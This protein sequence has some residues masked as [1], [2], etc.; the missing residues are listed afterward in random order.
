MGDS[1]SALAEAMRAIDSADRAQVE[2]ANQT[3]REQQERIG[4]E[5]AAAN[6]QRL[7]SAQQLLEQRAAG[8]V[9]FEGLL[10]HQWDGMR[11]GYS[12]RRWLLADGM[13]LGKTRTMIGWLDLQA[14]RRTVIVC[15]AEIA[16][17]FG[18]EILDVAPHRRTTILTK[19]SPVRRERLLRVAL[20]HDGIIV[21]NFEL[22]RGRNG[23]MSRLLSDLILWQA[24]TV[25]VDEAHNMKT[26]KS[27]NYQLVEQL[28]MADN[29]CVKCGSAML[30]VRNEKKQPIPCGFCGWKI[31]DTPTPLLPIDRLMETKSVK[32]LGLTTGTP[33]LNS[34]EDLYP[35]LHLIDPI[36]FP[37]KKAFTEAFCRIDYSIGG[38]LV[39]LASGLTQLR[40]MI[41]GNFLART[42]AD[43][44]IV[45]PPQ[46]VHVVTV[47]IDPTTHPDQARV[48]RQIAEFAKIT[49]QNGNEHTIMHAM[50][51]LTRKRQS[52]VW[53]AGIEIRDTDSNSPTHG[54]VIFRVGDEV[55]E[56]AK[57]DAL[58]ANIATQHARGARQ[59]VFSQFKTALV[60]VEKRLLDAGYH[61]ARFDGD[62]PAAQREI[63]KGDFYTT[64]TDYKYDI[65][66]VHYRSGGTGLNLTRATVTHFL[67]EEW[68]PGR[69]EQAK[70]RTHR[71]GQTEETEV[72][73][74]RSSGK[75]AQVDTFMANLNKLKQRLIEDFDSV[76][77]SDKSDLLA[78]LEQMIVED[79]A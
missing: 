16:P 15:Q 49:L 60:A 6:R 43:A 65:V 73:I 61:V 64:H 37:F 28:V 4:A 9:W 78:S 58:C 21:V 3:R 69:A 1:L 56:S 45:L 76:T 8:R 52:V 29:T 47:P 5:Q 38:R 42:R 39:W 34:P 63:I 75:G 32:H 41:Q 62:T 68:N 14:A 51:W 31:G 27:K 57:I 35:L 22:L 18:Q 33:I 26:T 30:G 44:G 50:A 19:Q 53:P 71:M 77:D 59:I 48:V 13:G 2:A 46:Q 24:D 55:Q 79:A 54:E 74:Y 10:P 72:F 17:Q 36:R 67:D 70:A 12:A 11:F 23:V 20:A 25:V 40:P 66:L 7:L